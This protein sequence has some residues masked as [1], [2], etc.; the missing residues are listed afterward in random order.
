VAH[1]R[2]GL[3]L[4][5]ASVPF[6]VEKL[7]LEVALLDEV[8]VDEPHGAHAG[9]HQQ[10]SLQRAQGAQAHDGHA[11]PHDGL[12]SLGADAPEEDLPRVPFGDGLCCRLRHARLA[13]WGSATVILTGA[14]GRPFPS[15]LVGIAVARPAP[16]AAA[17]AAW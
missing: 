11:R 8:A 16:R 1:R 13:P 6:V 14:V 15:D 12:L 4:E 3:G 7:P 17:A 9:A 5:R 2:D 10:R